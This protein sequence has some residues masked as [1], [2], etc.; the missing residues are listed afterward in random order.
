M[1]KGNFMALRARRVL[2]LA[3]LGLVAAAGSFAAE[4]RIG[5][6]PDPVGKASEEPSTTA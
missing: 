4:S 2:F 3:F 6:K 5:V 1:G